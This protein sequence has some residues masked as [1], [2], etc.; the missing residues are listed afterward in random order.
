[1]KRLS[2]VA[3]AV[4][5][6]VLGILLGG[7]A[8]AYPDP[9]PPLPPVVSPTPTGSPSPLTG[10]PAG[11]TATGAVGGTLPNAGGPPAG[12]AILGG[13]LVALGGLAGLRNRRR[14][15]PQA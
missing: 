15:S 8:Q 13:V 11:G 5:S 3:L 14:R 4:L 6:P 10:P 9:I 2:A 12:I 7:P 1:M